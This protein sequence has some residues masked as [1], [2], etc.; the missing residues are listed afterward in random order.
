MQAKSIFSNT[1]TEI[2]TALEQCMTVEQDFKP[3]LAFV[4]TS[5]KQEWQHVQALLN[6]EGIAIFGATTAGEFTEDGITNTGITILLLDIDPG[7]FK[8]ILK[9]NEQNTPFQSASRIAATGMESFSNPAFIILATHTKTPGDDIINGIAEKAGTGVTIIGGIAGDTINLGGTVFTNNSSCENGILCLVLDQD[10]IDVK[11]IA[12]SGWKPLGTEKKVTKS[13]GLWVYT[14]D[15][16]PAMD[17]VE[18][19]TGN[20]ILDDDEADNIVKLNTTYPLQV[21]RKGSSPAMIPT[22]FLN[23]ESRA[24]MCS[25]HI[26]AGT[27]FR[28][29]LPPDFDVI[30]T[31]IESSRKLKENNLPDADALIVFSCV[32]RLESL[33]PMMSE[34]LQGLAGTWQKPMAGFFSL[35][36]FGTVAG[37][38]PEFHGTTCSWVALKEK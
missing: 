20:V 31:V 15:D 2:T 9:D 16:Q 28:F 34:E 10:K 1:I 38:K 27:G 17:I 14:I 8:I 30:E 6:K 11:G 13:E 35:G 21:N 26:P 18:K 32:G 7:H 3:A 37:G 25:Q 33:G 29:S 12:V 22:L 24:I 36:E 23:K 5:L 4:F 19:Y